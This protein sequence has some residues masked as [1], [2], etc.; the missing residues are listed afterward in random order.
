MKVRAQKAAQLSGKS[1][2]TIQRHMND[3]KLSFE[4]DNEGKKVIDTS[5]LERVFGA[6][7]SPGEK[8]SYSSDTEAELKRATEML[9]MERMKMRIRYLEDQNHTLE[10]QLDDAKSQRDQWQKQAQQVL[11][12][13]QYSQQQAEELKEQLKERDRREMA[14]RKQMMEA[15]MKAMQAESQ[16]NESAATDAA[17]SEQ[18][19]SESSTVSQPFARSFALLR[20]K[21]RGTKSQENAA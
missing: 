2:S 9:E 3:G 17:S 12:T 16:D 6:L 7:K 13:S 21:M 1:K 19:Q 14:R 4:L 20:E 10:T 8:R 18:A 15:K 11:L 5:E